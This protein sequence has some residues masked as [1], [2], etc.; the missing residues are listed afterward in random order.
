[1]LVESIHLPSHT[2]DMPLAAH[3]HL[4]APVD[5][6]EDSQS[7]HRRERPNSCCGPWRT[8][9]LLT[10]RMSDPGECLVRLKAVEERAI[11]S[12]VVDLDSLVDVGGICAQ[13][14]CDLVQG[15][16]CDIED[17]FH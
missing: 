14:H 3:V 12:Y 2:A 8:T 1:M 9:D 11:W 4:T 17:H 7:H 10:N 13:S 15:V 6:G 5:P 16:A